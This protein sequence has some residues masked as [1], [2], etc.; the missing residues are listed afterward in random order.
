ML[1]PQN[2]FSFF[3]NCIAI[4]SH[5][6]YLV[7]PFF[8][9]IQFLNLFLNSD[10]YFLYNLSIDFATFTA[11]LLGILTIISSLVIRSVNVNRA[12]HF[13]FL[14]TTK[15]PS[16][17]PYSLLSFAS[18]GLKSILFSAGTFIQ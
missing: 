14:P 9:Y 13:P 18:C 5:Y 7:N 3:S 4:L 11:C 16:Q 15:S 6:V 10:L 12:A 8:L 2:V 17:C 1:A